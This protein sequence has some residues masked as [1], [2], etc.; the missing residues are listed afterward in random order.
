MEPGAKH[1]HN[2]LRLLLKVMG[3]P[4]PDAQAALASGMT[5]E[6]YLDHM[7]KVEKERA[8]ASLT[9]VDHLLAKVEGMR[10]VL[11]MRKE[12]SEL[13]GFLWG[14]HTVLEQVKNHLQLT[15]GERELLSEFI[16]QLKA[17]K[18]EQTDGR[19]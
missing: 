8:F 10:F 12:S 17:T 16:M 6:H 11:E 14:V 1:T 13:V 19:P 2:D 5:L 18:K 15:Q 9:A 7:D 3:I 4:E